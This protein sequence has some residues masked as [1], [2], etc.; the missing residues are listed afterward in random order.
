MPAPAQTYSPLFYIDAQ[1]DAGHSMTLPNPKQDR[2]LFIRR[3]T[4]ES[5]AHCLNP[6]NS[7]WSNPTPKSA[8]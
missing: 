8:S 2:A 7:W 3:G 6:V 4:V 5:G 1:I